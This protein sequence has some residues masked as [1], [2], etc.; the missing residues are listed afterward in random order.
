M[1]TILFHPERDADAIPQAAAILRRGG[2]LGIPTET[3]YGLGADALN[4]TAVRHIFE[5]KGRPQDNPLIIHVPDASWLERYCREVPETA[6]RLAERF[7]P[8]PLTMILPR[9]ENVPL[10]TT[11]GLETVGVRCPDHPV[12]RAIIEAAGVPVAAPSGNTSGRPSPTTA[13]HMAEDMDGKID[14]IVDGGPCAVGVES[15]I[16]DLTVTPPRLL[17]PGGLPLEALEEVL[18]TVAVDKAVTG[19]LK[20][21]EK[22]RAP[23][24]KY[25]HYAPKAPVTAVTGDP[26]HSA[27]VIRGL[28]REKAGVICF[29]EFA[30]YFEGHIVHRLGPFTDKLAQA[31]AI[32]R[33]GGLLGIPTETVYGLGADALNETAVRH[34]FEAKGRPQDN[35]L[36]IHVPDASW[37]ERYCREVPETAYR[38]AERFWPG[39][40]TMILPRRENVPLQTTGGL[41]TVGVRCPDHPVTRA[42]I[43]AAGVPVAAPSGNTSG[44]PSPTTAGH[45][46]EDMDGKI[47]GIVDGGPCAVGV[48]STIIDLTVTPPRLLR[49]GGLPLEALE[50]VLG[51]VAVDKAVTGLLKDGEKPRAPGMKYRHYAPK[52]PVTAVTGD[53]AH[54]ALVIRGLLREKAGVIC[55]DEFA[56]YFEGHIV[57]R[58]GPFTDKLA[59]AQRV[60][61]A[62]RTF[63]GTDVTEIFAQCPD[64]AGLGLAVGNR[65]KKAAGFHLIDGDAPVVIGIT[66]GTGSGKTSALQALEALGGTVLDCDAVY[67]QALRE[68]ETLRRRIRDAFGEVF[69]GTELDRQ[70]LGSLVFSDPQALERLNGIIFDYLPGVLRRKMEGRVLVGLDAIN[71]IES[72]LGE[73]CCR[74]VAVLAP[75]EQRVQRIMQ[76]DHIPEEY[77]RLRIQA[78]KPDSYYREH[79]TDVLENQEE[80]PEAFR[81]K[82]EIFFRDLLRQ[83]HHITEGGHEQ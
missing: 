76:R 6:Y 74:T 70:K 9:R 36:I 4:E 64:D 80:T 2:L 21:G 51:T 10:Q 19:L 66:G 63:D 54:S 69:R 46:A 56:G 82:A 34:I 47:D 26:A 59:Q 20:D 12:T 31:A 18:G 15:T 60:F 5:A 35:P 55:F 16:I 27:L 48:E 13:G 72:G 30:G 71:L 61:D 49:P 24:M 14:G 1:K 78:Q 42:I 81:E 53:P 73:L 68:D 7:W 41:E 3:V 45:M 38:L 62:L 39:P 33:R 44:R 65:L 77:A 37:L 75:G 79:C 23:G 29:D 28:L 40:L 83:L 58:L 11:G 25:R 67:H 57:H 32:L 8:G 52:A 50:E 43:E 22:P 17:R